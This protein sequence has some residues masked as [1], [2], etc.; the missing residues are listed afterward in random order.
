M[1]I[2]NNISKMSFLSRVF[3]AT[4]TL[5]GAV[6]NASVAAFKE[7]IGR[8]A[9]EKVTIEPQPRGSVLDLIDEEVES[10]DVTPLSVSDGSDVHLEF[11]SMSDD[12]ILQSILNELN[13][14]FK[15][16]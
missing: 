11:D 12:A 5:A 8:P 10:E 2:N 1:G 4:K 13:G 9:E 3:S 7:V 6:Y 15:P 14:L 16:T